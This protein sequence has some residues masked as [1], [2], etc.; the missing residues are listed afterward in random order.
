VVAG[1]VN[2][3]ADS[4]A[5]GPAST[6]PLTKRRMSHDPLPHPARPPRSIAT[7]GALEHD[8]DVVVTGLG[9]ALRTLLGGD[10]SI[11]RAAALL[12]LDAAEVKR[13]TKP[14]ATAK[15]GH[16]P[17]QSPAPTRSEPR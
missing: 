5:V 12:E 17:K 7:D 3:V 15:V 10:V 1:R 4:T 9:E 8:D 16:G 13:L 6:L 14:R 2:E 11:E